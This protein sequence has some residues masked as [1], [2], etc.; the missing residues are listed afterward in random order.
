MAGVGRLGSPKVSWCRGDVR[1][2]DICGVGQVPSWPRDRQLR[3]PSVGAPGRAGRA[4]VLG[5][6]GRARGSRVP[7]PVRAVAGGVSLDRMQDP[8]PVGRSAALT[9]LE[10]RPGTAGAAAG[11]EA[12]P[13]ISPRCASAVSKFCA[14]SRAFPP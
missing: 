13:V 12:V 5:P 3:V 11:G 1:P 6:A 7:A 10:G 8:G 9:P 4:W 2:P 14:L